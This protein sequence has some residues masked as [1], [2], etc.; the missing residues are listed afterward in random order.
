MATF[1]PAMRPRSPWSLMRWLPVAGLV[2]LA[3]A[4]LAYWWAGSNPEGMK[5]AIQEL[6]FWPDFMNQP[7]TY[8]REQQFATAAAAPGRDKT[9]EELAALRAE[10]E[11]L[12]AQQAIRP[13]VVT[14]AQPAPQQAVQRAV[15]RPSDM[16]FI[17]KPLKESAGP[18]LPTYRLAPWATKLPCVVEMLLNSEVPGW[19]TCKITAPVYDTATGQH[20]LIPP[21]STIGAKYS[22]EHLLYGNE[23]LPTVALEVTLPNGTTV[24]LGQAPI[25]DQA[26]TTGLTGDVD[27]H[28]W[29]LFGAIFIGGALKGGAQAMTA[30]AASAGGADAVITG[31]GQ[32]GSQAVNQRVSRALDTRPTIRVFPGQRGIVLMTKPVDLPAFYR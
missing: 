19:F 24:D 8:K 5:S 16:L 2:V 12:K 31:I 3:V 21:G 30:A 22:S 20:L 14:P 27:Q 26:G 17:T 25:M 9:A 1:S 18:T 4:A 11:R 13:A 23:R 28:Y 7:T 6:G 32:T 15:K 29:R 10:L